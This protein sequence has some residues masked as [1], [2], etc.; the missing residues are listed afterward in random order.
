MKKVPVLGKLEDGMDNTIKDL[1]GPLKSFYPL[2]K[3]GVILSNPATLTAYAAYR[4]IPYALDG[5]TSDRAMKSYKAIGKTVGKGA[6]ALGLG[7]I[8]VGA[9]LGK[10]AVTGLASIG[11]QQ[12][13]N[14]NDYFADK[15]FSFSNIKDKI[16]DLSFTRKEDYQ[17]ERV[18]LQ[19]RTLEQEK[20]AF[21]NNLRGA[22][23]LFGF[24]R[25]KSEKDLQRAFQSFTNRRQYI[26]P[27][28][29]EQEVVEDI[30][31]EEIN[32]KNDLS[33]LFSPQEPETIE[34]SEPM[35]SESF[36]KDKK[37]L[38]NDYLQ[39]DE[40]CSVHFT[41]NNDGSY[42]QTFEIDGEMGQSM[43]VTE[44]Q[45]LNFYKD[46]DKQKETEVEKDNDFVLN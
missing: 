20:A 6:L 35:S 2:L 39:I 8:K 43:T 5:L 10:E 11:K 40:N 46:L 24:E 32:H 26:K 14:V 44:E 9:K 25:P 31:K 21:N 19:S 41:R 42:S 29:R 37:P 30:A 45:Y 33:H 18:S 16:T 3:A 7:A 36:Y 12:L 27:Y 38:K 13:N 4:A 15:D 28:V 17:N 22:S 23:V 34:F 1:M